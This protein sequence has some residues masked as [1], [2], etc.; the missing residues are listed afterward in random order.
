MALRAQAFLTSGRT[1]A[2]GGR[3]LTALED[4]NGSFARF[5]REAPKEARADLSYAITVTTFA[6]EQRMKA[7]VR[8]IAY[9]TGDMYRAVES[10]PPRRQGLTGRAGILNAPAEAEVALFNEYSPNHQPFMRPSVDQEQKDFVRRVTAAVA[11]I[12]RDY[13]PGGRFL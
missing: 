1:V 9:L 6:V 2:R 5:L 7:R 10:A 3:R 12:D 4:V 8:E 11:Q 13:G